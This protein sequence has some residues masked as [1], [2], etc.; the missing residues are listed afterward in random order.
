MRHAAITFAASLGQSQGASDDFDLI[1]CSSMLDL[2]TFRGLASADIARLPAIVYFHENQLTYPVR[3]EEPRDVHFGLTQMNACLA[4]QEVW[5][6]SSFHL[7]AFLSRLSEI[8][9]TMPPAELGEPVEAIHR[10]S[11]VVPPPVSLLSP[12]EE[13]D[14]NKPLHLLWSARWEHDKNPEAFFAALK[15]LVD[16][17]LDFRVSVLGE[18]FREV[19]EVFSNSLEWLGDRVLHWGFQQSRNDYTDV[20]RRADVFV[21][22]AR[23]EFFG[24]A[25]VEAMSAGVVPLLPDRLSYPELLTRMEL[26]ED[27]QRRLLFDGSPETLAERIAAMAKAKRNDTIALEKEEGVDLGRISKIISTSAHRAFSL[28]KMIA[29]CD[30]RM[31][32]LESEHPFGHGR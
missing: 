28:E 21:S 22:T 29:L 27:L 30:D 13:K 3:R 2:A 6:N 18:R 7:E 1:F 10:K 12:L 8:L 19:P 25:T 23:H 15:L 20:V 26:E 24:I 11:R 16:R 9:K 5:F 14:K 31:A 17:G 32:S 4:A